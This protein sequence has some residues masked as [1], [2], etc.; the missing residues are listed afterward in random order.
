LIGI[1]SKTSEREIVQE[2]FELFKTPWEFYDE[3]RY[4]DVVLT[5]GD[6]ISEIETKLLLIYGSNETRYDSENGIGIGSNKK[7]ALLEYDEWNLPI[8]KNILTFVDSSSPVLRIKESSD[9]VSVVAGVEINSKNKKILRIGYDL[10]QEIYFLLSSGQSIEYAHIPTTEIHISILRNLILSS[11]ISLIEIPPI[12]SG[13]DFITCLTHDVDF[14]G[15]RF[16]R[17]DRTMFGFVYRALIG[18]LIGV[19]KGRTSWKKLLKNWKAVILLPWVY[20]GCAEDF[21]NQFDRYIEIEKGL[22]AT[23]FVIP[24]KNQDGQDIS[25]KAVKG[26]AIRY[27]VT[28][29]EPELQKLIE[30]GCE[31]GLHGIDAWRSSKKG[32]DE[33][34]RILQF[35]GE[36]EI[37]LRMHWLYFHNQSPQ[38]LEDAGFYY[39]SSYGYNE[40]VGFRGGTTQV[41]RPQNAKKLFELPLHIQD[42]ALFYPGRMG[43]TEKQARNLVDEI[44]KNTKKYGG[45][46]TINWHQRSLGP[47]RLWDDFYIRLIEDLKRLNVCF[48]RAGDAVKWFHKRRSVFFEKAEFVESSIKLKLG[49]YNSTQQPGLLVRI[50]RPIEIEKETLVPGKCK[51]IYLDFPLKDKTELEISF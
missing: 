21:F 32:R 50:H 19:L 49:G 16:H 36:T 14:A 27:D 42:T 13:Y 8:Y 15:V 11:G 33:L 7:G 48:A 26:R 17:F 47:D 4:Y 29:I 39:D 31:I 46:L 2:F 22:G 43:L 38:I 10:F 41:F 9:T 28:D 3:N 23:F 51:R 5:T 12:P 35:I 40:A 25:G 45:L 24:Y 20:I 1:I 6:Y 37:G 18:S 34:N 30:S 44:L